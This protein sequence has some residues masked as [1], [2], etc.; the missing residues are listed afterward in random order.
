MEPNIQNYQMMTRSFCANQ[1]LQMT[2]AEDIRRAYERPYIRL[3]GE[4]F[5]IGKLPVRKKRTGFFRR[6]IRRISGKRRK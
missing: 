6:M 4:T 3:G 1:L 2:I 5:Y